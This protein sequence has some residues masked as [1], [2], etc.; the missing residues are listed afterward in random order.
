M[1]AA[2]VL[3][4]CKDGEEKRLVKNLEKT[5]WI[6]EVQP[7]IGHYD[8]IAKITSHSIEKMEEII[9]EIHRNDLIHATKVLRMNDTVTA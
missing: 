2:F 4:K 3:M 1:P 9:E 7:T 5:K 6:S 8:L